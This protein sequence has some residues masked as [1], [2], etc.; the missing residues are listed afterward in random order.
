MLYM[1]QEDALALGLFL[2]VTVY[3]SSHLKPQCL[4]DIFPA[5]QFAKTPC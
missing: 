1:E 2:Q 3:T 5:S 4:K